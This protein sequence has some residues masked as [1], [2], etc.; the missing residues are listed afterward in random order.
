MLQLKNKT[1]FEGMI[2]PA[3]DPEGVETIYTIIKGTFR[4]G[5]SVAIADVQVPPVIAEEYLGEPGRSSLKRA[6]DISLV[7]PSTDVL[8]LGSAHAPSGK[9]VSELDVSVTVGLVRKEVR[10]FGDRT[11][12]P[13]VVRSTI[14]RPVPF[15][16]MPLVWERAFGGT[17]LGGEDPPVTASEPRNPVGV[18]FRTRGNRAPVDGSP[19][20]NL[21]DPAQLIASWKDRPA[22]ASFGPICPHWEPR[23][24]YT[25]T[26]DDDWEQNRIPYFPRDF[27]TRF[28]QQATPD[29]I[30]PAY[31]TGGEAVEVVGVRPEGV[32]RF[33]LPRFS[34]RTSYRL[35]NAVFDRPTRLDTVIIEPDEARLF[36]VWRSAF[37]C[38]K[39][40]LRV[41]EIEARLDER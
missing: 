41:H 27:D 22:P 19:L 8:L 31:L 12:Q 5:R 11:W 14:S 28:F 15:V 29:L 21:E 37:P 39:K 4:L 34:V 30:A 2:I 18:G 16:T 38:D 13:G 25:G 23:R 35:D 20:P 3:P 9:A 26:Y 7:K 10:V 24:S 33:H 36:L 32:L 6:S 17:E 1:P 40:T